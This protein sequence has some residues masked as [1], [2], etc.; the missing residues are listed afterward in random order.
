VQLSRSSQI[1]SYPLSRK[2]RGGRRD[3]GGGFL[4]IANR[5]TLPLCAACAAEV[6]RVT[7]FCMD[8]RNPRLILRFQS[9]PLALPVLCTANVQFAFILRELLRVENAKS[10]QFH[11]LRPK[12]IGLY[13]FAE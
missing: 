10:S 3:M 12:A 7:G 5:I 8:Q 11:W 6:G 9:V 4:S 1:E 2:Q 13:R